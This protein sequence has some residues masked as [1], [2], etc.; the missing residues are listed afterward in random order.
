LFFAFAQIVMV[1]SE[2]L[3][4]LNDEGRKEMRYENFYAVKDET[5]ERNRG[6]KVKRLRTRPDT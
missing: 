3:D 6:A 4:S 1:E 2:Q 5:E